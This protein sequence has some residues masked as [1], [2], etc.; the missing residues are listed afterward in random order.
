MI[1]NYGLEARKWQLLLRP[2]ERF[3]LVKAFKSV[4]AGCSITMLTPNRIGEYGG[5][6]LFVKENNRLRAISLTILGSISQLTITIIM[7]TIGLLAL[8][9]IPGEDTVVFTFIPKVISNA[10]LLVCIFL[11][12]FLLMFYLRIAWLIHLME[13]VKFLAKP[14]KYVRLLDQ[15]SGKQLLRILF[16][17]LL[18]YM[19]FI[20]QYMLLLHVMDVSINY[21]LCF[22]LLSIFYLVMVLA[23][24]IGFTELPL[25][26][27]ATVEIFKLYSPN[28][29]GIQAA[30]LGIWLI[31]LVMPAII[32]SILILG[33][34]ITK[35]N[36][37]NP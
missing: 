17:S 22:W 20:L 25:R 15:F 6:I 1:V 9:F 35:E 11:S 24:S 30:A 27:T 33:I 28:L 34:K 29:I 36:E 2:L 7:G 5:R 37:E 13:K 3:S 10:L 18:R 21:L 16:L 4:M 8:T 23:P 19:A 26:A 14:L 32:G 12:I 31:N